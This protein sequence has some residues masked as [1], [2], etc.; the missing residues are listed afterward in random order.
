MRI[1]RASRKTRRAKTRAV[2]GRGRSSGPRAASPRACA[3]ARARAKRALAPGA[4][5]NDGFAPPALPALVAERREALPRVVGD[6]PLVNACL[7]VRARARAREPRTPL[8][9]PRR[10]RARRR[11]AK[12]RARARLRSASPRSP[13]P[14]TKLRASF[15]CPLPLPHARRY[16]GHGD[17]DAGIRP[18]ADNARV[19]FNLW[20]TPDEARRALLLVLSRSRSRAYE[21]QVSSDLSLVSLLFNAAAVPRAR[22]PRAHA[23]GG[24]ADDDDED[25]SAFACVP[26][27]GRP[28]RK[29]GPSGG[30]R[31]TKLRRL[32]RALSPRSPRAQVSWRAHR[33]GRGAEGRRRRRGLRDWNDFTEEARIRAW[34]GDP[35][36]RCLARAR[37][38]RYRA[39]RAVIFDSDLLHETARYRFGG[40]YRGRRINLPLLFGSRD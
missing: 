4:Y 35:G 9:T 30:E 34:M 21:A 18:H 8:N 5:L 37:R 24:A 33:H 22:A 7:Q 38:V 10:A 28:H 1:G 39:N 20:L 13:P 32:A 23:T 2:R 3:L 6:L 25:A 26:P 29:T 16:G 27:L 12:R 15:S 17:V 14:R 19:N 11:V 40:G 36:R 31:E